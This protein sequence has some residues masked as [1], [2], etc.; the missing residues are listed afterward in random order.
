MSIGGKQLNNDHVIE[1]TITIKGIP[2]IL[3]TPISKTDLH[4]T[5]FFYHGWGSNKESQR[6]RGF[7]LAT[8]GFQVVLPDAV[9][10][11][12]RGTIDYDLRENTE[13]YFWKVILNNVMESESLIEEIVENYNGDKN[14]IGVAGHSMGGF[15]ASGI[16]TS[17][18]NVKALAVV[19]GSCAWNHT[20]HEFA[21]LLDLSYSP[22][23]MKDDQNVNGLDPINHIEK[24]IDRPILLLHGDKDSLVPID[25]QRIFYKKIAPLYLDKAKINFIEYPRLNHHLTTE[26]MEEIYRFFKKYLLN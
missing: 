10:H 11:G 1:Q 2:A 19:N 22:T 6:F 24:L 21:K 12:Q 18:Q 23:D 14:R 16:F 9:Y 26:M 3:F 17:N 20:N 13:K 5:I 8:L 7:M 15:T 4:P 25:S